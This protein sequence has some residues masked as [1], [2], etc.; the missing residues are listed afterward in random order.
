[1]PT[2]GRLTLVE[3]MIHEIPHGRFKISGSEPII[4]TNSPTLLDEKTDRFV[5]EEMLQPALNSGRQ[6]VE[7][8][9]ATS[10]VTQL[11][12]EILMDSTLLPK[13]SKLIAKHMHATQ[14]SASSNG[15]FMASIAHEDGELRFI[16]LKAE[17]QEG[18]R[19]K[20]SMVEEELVFEVEHLTQLIIGQNSRVYKIVMFW[21]KKETGRL[22]GVM[23]DMQN[24]SSFANYF[25]NDFLG[26]E[27]THRA[28][29]QTEEFVKGLGKIVNSAQLSTE[30][31]TRYA[32]AAVAYLESPTTSINP[33]KFITDFIDPEDRD[34]VASDFLSE[35]Q[36]QIFVKD[37]TLV[38]SHIGGLKM[39]ISSG[40]TIS[41]T[42][43]AMK[44]GTVK[45]EPEAE[46]GP[47]VIVKGALE[48]FEM[49][50]PP[51]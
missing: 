26:C 41:A 2:I 50:R 1:M 4:L 8:T 30:K 11:V 37:L 12:R 29:I 17:H 5:R 33:S 49:S 42:P 44:D 28:E 7:V 21:I 14:A 19:L 36:E 46:D 9:P 34:L 23:V 13:N 32:T 15:V 43:Q 39:K 18:V 20:Y 38:K 10:V 3:T 48:I 40:V 22:F 47:R 51:K 25:L 16:I 27:L 35:V 31:R 45:F 24:G 6:V